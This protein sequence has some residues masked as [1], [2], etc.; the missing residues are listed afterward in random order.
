MSVPYAMYAGNI[1][2]TS[3]NYSNKW[4]MVSTR[5]SA[6]YTFME[7]LNY[8]AVLNESGYSD[9]RMPTLEE[10]IDWISIDG[11][12]TNDMSSW[13]K[14]PTNTKMGFID[15]QEFFIVQINGQNSLVSSKVSLTQNFSFNYSNYDVHFP[16]ICFR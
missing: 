2:N 8:C 5:S 3:S 12:P 1:L 10:V 6:S 7:A 11:L 16:T 15:Q 13:T 14:T 9:W 4:T